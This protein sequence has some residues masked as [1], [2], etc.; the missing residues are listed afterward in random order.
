M[1]G[2]D[3][4][5]AQPHFD[6]KFPQRSVCRPERERG[7]VGRRRQVLAKDIPVLQDDRV[8]PHV[9][10]T[11]V[12]LGRQGRHPEIRLMDEQ[13]ERSLIMGVAELMAEVKPLPLLQELDRTLVPTP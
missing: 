11:I 5:I 9:R 13:A 3:Q 1:T 6:S 10:T 2:G 4:L 7:P 12:K 8:R